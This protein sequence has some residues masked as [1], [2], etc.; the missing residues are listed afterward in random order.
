M[1]YLAL[2][3]DAADNIKGVNGIGEKKARN[4]VQ[5][6]Q[7]VENIYAHLESIEPFVANILRDQ[8]EVA[9]FSKS[10]VQLAEVDLSTIVLGDFRFV[11]DYHHYISVLGEKYGFASLEKLVLDMKKEAERPQQLGLF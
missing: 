2:L 7:T 6:F 10:M 11:L 5:Q 9:L 8:K 1:D 3:G 4:L